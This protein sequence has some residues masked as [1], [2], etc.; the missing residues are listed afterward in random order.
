MP[1]KAAS[2]P[3]PGVQSAKAGVTTPPARKFALTAP[4]PLEQALLGQIVDY[5]RLEQGRRRVVWFARTNGGGMF[6]KTKR[7]LWF[8]WLYLRGVNLAGR[9][10]ADVH[11]MLQGGRYFALEVKCPDQ[12]ATETQILFLEAV[13]DGGGIAAVVRSAEDVRSL[14]FGEVNGCR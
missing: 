12:K 8:Y 10:L 5:L 3:I 14:L 7:W 2:E 4:Q 11:G 1:R 13:R 6:D 9:G